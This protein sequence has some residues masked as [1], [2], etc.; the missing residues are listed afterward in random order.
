MHCYHTDKWPV[1]CPIEAVFNS[2][3]LNTLSNDPCDLNVLSPAHSLVVD[4]LKTLPEPSI[5]HIP[6]SCLSKWE[7]H[8]SFLNMFGQGVKGIHTLA[9]FSSEWSEKT[10]QDDLECGKSGTLKGRQYSSSL[11]WSVDRNTFLQTTIDS[12]L[13]VFTDKT[14]S[15]E[16][17]VQY[18]KNVV[19]C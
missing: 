10:V 15:G 17:R 11:S 5:M 3:Q 18:K 13:R 4:S 9:A 6:K 8:K 1:L 7:Q 14:S 19:H 12:L 16:V 2:R